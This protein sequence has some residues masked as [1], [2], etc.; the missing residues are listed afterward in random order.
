MACVRASHRPAPKT[1]TQSPTTIRFALLLR[2]IRRMNHSIT[3]AI[4]ETDIMVMNSLVQ[5]K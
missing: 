1:T 5:L 4:T 3:S 2:Y